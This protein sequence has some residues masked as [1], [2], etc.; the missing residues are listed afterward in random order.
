M[1]QDRI[2]EAMKIIVGEIQEACRR[3]TRTHASPQEL[4]KLVAHAAFNMLRSGKV[5][6]EQVIEQSGVEKYLNTV[7]S[8]VRYSCRTP[9][10]WAL[11]RFR[12]LLPEFGN[13][14]ATDEI[15]KLVS[16]MRRDL[17]QNI[18]D[19][20]LRIGMLDAAIGTGL[21]TVTFDDYGK[22]QFDDTKAE[23]WLREISAFCELSELNERL[24][25]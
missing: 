25:N 7:S 16:G 13:D 4:G 9:F 19:A 2:D 5:H 3:R 23:E 6:Y 11:A 18:E 12:E 24:V 10:F 1:L 15:K 14:Y 21:L 22:L 17:L 8:L 20:N